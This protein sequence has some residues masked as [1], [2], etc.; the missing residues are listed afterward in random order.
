MKA[1]VLGVLTLTLTACGGAELPPGVTPAPPDT[2][3]GDCAAA[4]ED[5]TDA[6]FELDSRLSVGMTFA[7][8]SD[9][10]ADTRV[11]YDKIKFTNLDRDCILGAGKPAEDA[12]N[13]YIKAYTAWN[14]CFNQSTCNNE[15]IKPTL[16]GHWATATAT[17]K[18]IK[19][20]LP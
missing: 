17:L 13:E 19:N 16:Q 14:D 5:L 12:M 18:A 10:V 15:S 20:R 2:V 11:A 1:L 8:Y 3:S 9:K 6:L 4:L 7:A